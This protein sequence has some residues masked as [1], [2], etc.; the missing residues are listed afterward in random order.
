[1]RASA[2]RPP[3][4]PVLS[5]PG[6]IR[7]EAT[8]AVKIRIPFLVNHDFFPSGFV[9]SSPAVRIYIDPVCPDHPQPADYILITHAHPDHFRKESIASLLKDETVILC[10]ERVYAKLKRRFRDQTLRKVSPGESY[11][12]PDLRIETVAAYNLQSGFLTPHPVSAGGVGYVIELD[13]LRIYHSGD[14]DLIPEM[15]L[16]RD[17]TAMLVPIDGGD[18]TM[19]TEEAAELVNEIRPALAVPMHYTI[20]SDEVLRFKSLADSSVKVIVL[21]GAPEE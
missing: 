12:F 5:L 19:S 21:D 15:R 6:E 13:G 7:L 10:P 17:L 11:E 14:S 8:G 9:L 16:L 1:M 3:V 4:P 20:G 2:V 18:L